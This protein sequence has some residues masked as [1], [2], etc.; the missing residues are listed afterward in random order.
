[1]GRKLD[2]GVEL[3]DEVEG[4]GEIA[5]KGSSAVYCVRLFLAQ[6]EEVTRD[7]TLIENYPEHV[8]VDRIEG[9]DLIEHTLKIG[10]RQAIA[11]IEKGLTGMRAGGYR[12]IVIAPHLAYRERGVPGSIPGNAL[13]RAR[14]W[15]RRVENP[16]QPRPAPESRS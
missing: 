7:K 12:E 11:G 10:S 15:L 3:L 4:D 1:M 6:G 13:I 8:V 5:R 2:K 16:V 9:V 14:I